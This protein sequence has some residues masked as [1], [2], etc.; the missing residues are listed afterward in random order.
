MALLLRRRTPSTVKVLCAAPPALAGVFV[1]GLAF[2][3]AVI[4]GALALT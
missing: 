4:G 3:L 1:T 2:G